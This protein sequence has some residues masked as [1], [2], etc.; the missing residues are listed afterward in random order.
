MS[1]VKRSWS[2]TRLGGG[3]GYGWYRGAA[4]PGKVFI[5]GRLGNVL[6]LVAM[7]ASSPSKYRY[8]MLGRW[9]NVGVV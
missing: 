8:V 4:G 2:G 5:I 7:L 6:L 1:L 9:L 3:I